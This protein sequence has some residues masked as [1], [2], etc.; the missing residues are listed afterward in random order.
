MADRIV[1]IKG[2]VI[3][4]IGEPHEVYMKPINI[5]VATFI[6]S[7][8]MNIFH[9]TGSGKGKESIFS[10]PF[11][12]S[13]GKRFVFSET[14]QEISLGIRPEDIDVVK[15]SEPDSIA[16]EVMLV[17]PIGS[18]TLINVEIEEQVSCKVRMSAS[19]LVREGDR[20]KL[21]IPPDKIHLFDK[22]GTR[23]PGKGE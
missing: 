9:G 10:G 6:G 21:K 20:V 22:D 13:F 23:I 19:S 8:Q 2:G 3:Q 18:D 11:S 7:P 12:M 14:K 5:F 15:D 1:V 4:Q 17:E 16:G